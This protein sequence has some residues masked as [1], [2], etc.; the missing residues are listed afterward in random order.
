MLQQ[1]KGLTWQ[2]R[3][4]PTP[5]DRM[6][7][8]VRNT[9]FGISVI[10]KAIDITLNRSRGGQRSILGVEKPCEKDSNVKIPAGS[11]GEHADIDRKMKLVRFK[12]VARVAERKMLLI[13]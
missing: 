9:K 4:P 6:E 1:N 5:T 2:A 12:V 3:V 8:Q 10:G 11:H 13:I 7:Q